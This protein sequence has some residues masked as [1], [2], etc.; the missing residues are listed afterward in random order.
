MGKHTSCIK[1]HKSLGR[2]VK[3]SKVKGLKYIIVKLIFAVKDTSMMDYFKH[4]EIKDKKENKS[5]VS[6]MDAYISLLY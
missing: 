6:A 3:L 4:K 2:K 5:H 1:L